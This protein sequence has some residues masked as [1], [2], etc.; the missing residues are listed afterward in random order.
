MTSPQKVVAPHDCTTMVE[1]RRGV[2]SLD[3]EIVALLARRYDYM[4]AAARIKPSRDAVRDEPRKAEVIANAVAH[5][6]ALGVPGDTVATL[7]DLL[8]EDS[9]ARELGWFDERAG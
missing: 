8:V 4:R 6:R 9:I 3:A 5:A 7:W 2:D 1:V